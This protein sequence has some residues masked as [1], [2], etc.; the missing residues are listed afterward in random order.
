M[1][2]S[3]LHQK[4]ERLATRKKKC[5][6]C[7]VPGT[8]PSTDFLLVLIPTKCAKRKYIPESDEEQHTSTT[9]DVGALVETDNE[10]ERSCA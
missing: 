9:K 10:E 7:M 3:E 5:L 6:V 2:L 4:H 1:F 8:V